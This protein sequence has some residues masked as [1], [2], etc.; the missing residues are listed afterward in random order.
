MHVESTNILMD[1]ADTTTFF[2]LETQHYPTIPEAFIDVP[3]RLAQEYA[4]RPPQMDNVI[5]MPGNELL[6]DATYPNIP[7]LNELPFYYPIKY[8]DI[9]PK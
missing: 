3:G 2:R 8:P 5:D 7:S 6:H 9:L 4:H 1:L